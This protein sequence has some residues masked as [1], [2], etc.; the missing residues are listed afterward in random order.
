MFIFCFNI[1]N[2]N[3]M[4][5]IQHI[6]KSDW[7]T[8]IYFMEENGDAYGRAYIYSDSPKTIYLEGLSVIESKRDKGFGTEIQEVREN[9]GRSVGCKYSML[10]VKSDSWMRKWYERRGYKNYGP[11]DLENHIWM[12]KKL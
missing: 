10:V 11:H 8:S 5:L 4:N 7:G 6:N 1:I 12:K 3:Y 2:Y 9:Y